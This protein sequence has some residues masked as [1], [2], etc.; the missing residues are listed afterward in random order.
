ME[1]NSLCQESTVL[2][3]GRSALALD[4][5]AL[6]RGRHG[7]ADVA[8]ANGAVVT[9]WRREFQNASDPAS[10]QVRA[11]SKRA[12]Q[13]SDVRSSDEKQYPSMHGEHPDAAIAEHGERI[14]GHLG[15]QGERGEGGV[16]THPP[17]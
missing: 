4:L 11:R 9:D 2:R 13:D 15:E 12:L 6:V 8:P 16:T 14:R 7:V 1:N 17:A 5:A 10:P 3:L